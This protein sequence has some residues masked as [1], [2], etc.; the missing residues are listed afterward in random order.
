MSPLEM[1]GFK[2]IDALSISVLELHFWS[3]DE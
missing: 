1:K 3:G 2:K